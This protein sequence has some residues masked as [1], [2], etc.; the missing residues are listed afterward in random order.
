MFSLLHNGT[1]KSPNDI[2]PHSGTLGPESSWGALLQLCLAPAPGPYRKRLTMS[3]RSLDFCQE[4]LVCY[5]GQMEKKTVTLVQ[6]LNEA[7]QAFNS[8]PRRVF[9]WRA[10]LRHA[11]ADKP[12]LTPA[13]SHSAS[14]IPSSPIAAL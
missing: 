11:G 9:T 5:Q 2:L 13:P 1:K 4:I 10:E 3:I 7:E 14:F 12:V 8:Q 6:K